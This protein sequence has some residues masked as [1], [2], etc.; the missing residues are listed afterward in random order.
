MQ[1]GLREY[2]EHVKARND[3]AEFMRLRDPRSEEEKINA[4]DLQ[5]LA[6]FDSELSNYEKGRT[7]KTIKH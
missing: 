3:Q 5:N 1:R 6:Q 7:C 2:A 4:S